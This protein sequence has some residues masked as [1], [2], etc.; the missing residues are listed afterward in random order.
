M[1]SSLYL[2]ETRFIDISNPGLR[3]RTLELVAGVD[4]LREQ[5]KIIF[6]FVR[7]EI[8][9][10]PYTSFIHPEDYTAS[11]ILQRGEGFCIPKASLFTAMMRIL[12]IPAKLYFADIKNHLAPPK[13]KAV[14]GDIFIY[15]CY[16][17][18]LI[19]DQW[20][21]LAPTFN[22]RM[23]EKIRV[24][25]NDFDGFNDALLPSVNLDG[26]LYVEYIKDRGDA[27]DILYDEIL[28]TFKNF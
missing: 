24:P 9:Y 4:D 3:Q 27:A 10:N 15:H 7:D 8:R 23:S 1:S 26:K 28:S 12:K 22:R 14:M 18:V 2:Q 19:D 5:V 16:C 6:H 11:E 25:V 17:G 21:K 20:I 13:L